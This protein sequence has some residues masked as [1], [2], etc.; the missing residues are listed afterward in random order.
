MIWGENPL[1]SE[2][3]ILN[4]DPLWSKLSIPSITD[5][6]CAM[7]DP[8]W[9]KSSFSVWFP[10]PEICKN[11]LAK[12]ARGYQRQK[13][14]NFWSLKTFNWP[15]SDQHLLCFGG[16]GCGCGCGCGRCC[17]CCCCCCRCRC[18]WCWCWC[19][20]CCSCCSCFCS[21]SSWS[22]TCRVAEFRC[23]VVGAST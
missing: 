22:C 1:F 6:V 10:P 13:E 14:D 9:L 21:W 12:V 3:S 18:C 7:G 17:C 11:Q 4:Q 5:Q 23:S 20:Y 16:C 15:L 19:W 8:A 2:R